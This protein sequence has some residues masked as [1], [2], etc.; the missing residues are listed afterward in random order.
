VMQHYRIHQDDLARFQVANFPYQVYSV[1]RE[2]PFRLQ[3]IIKGAIRTD[4]RR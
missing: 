3:R 4:R 1:P 2:I